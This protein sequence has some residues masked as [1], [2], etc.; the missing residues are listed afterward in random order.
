M[1]H[2]DALLVGINATRAEENIPT[3][4]GKPVPM[5]ELTTTKVKVSATTPSNPRQ[6]SRYDLRPQIRITNCMYT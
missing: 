1:I 4:K 3:P 2:P 6:N 5:H